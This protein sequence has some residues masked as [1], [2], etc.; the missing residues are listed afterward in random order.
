MTS[1]R[2]YPPWDL[3]QQAAETLCAT[4][5]DVRL[6]I[7]HALTTTSKVCT[8]RIAR[9]MSITAP[10]TLPSGLRGC[11]I[12]GTPGVRIYPTGPLAA[13]FTIKCSDVEIVGL[14]ADSASGKV[15]TA[16]ATLDPL[17]TTDRLTIERCKFNGGSLVM[18]QSTGS[19]FMARILDNDISDDFGV[20]GA[21]IVL[22]GQY[23]CIEGNTIIGKA[24]AITLVGATSG[25]ARIFGNALGGGA[26]D[27]SAGNG[28]SIL[29][30]NPNAGAKTLAAGDLDLDVLSPGRLIRAPQV[31]T[32]GVSYAK[33]AGCK[34][35]VVELVGGGGGG[36]GCSSAASSGACGGGG[37]SGAYASKRYDV[38]ALAGPFTYAIGAAGL[39]GT[40]AGGTGGN[41]GDTTFT[42]GTTLVTAKGGLGGVGEAAGTA[43]AFVAGGAGQ[44]STLGDLNGAGSPGEYAQRLSG[45]A[46]VSGGGGS[47]E[48]GGGGLA[49][50][51][52]GAGN[53]GAGIGG[54]GGGALVL[55]ASA[56]AIGGAGSAG[57]LRIW[58]F[59]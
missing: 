58:E 2:A 44:L 8:L 42:D 30:V 14:R 19:T 7:T 18:G 37:A 31:L 46:A 4:E 53:A 29:G 10:F 39:A 20:G 22:A 35:I 24:A 26:V 28:T 49:R 40:N 25:L 21:G 54:G 5:A 27:L 36:G 13:L 23:W 56:A 1:T 38:S 47:S 57:A 6:A 16:F 41:G 59:T 34:S 50:T 17:S 15:I 48:W 55:S 43:A 9:T 52:A 12:L 51:T 33:P 45:T 3:R 11:R 32:A